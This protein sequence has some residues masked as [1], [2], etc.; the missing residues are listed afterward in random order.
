MKN[1]IR[2]FLMMDDGRRT[3][4]DTRQS[5]A[6]CH[7][8]MGQRTYPG[9]NAA[10]QFNSSRGHVF[11]FSFLSFLSF[12][13]SSCCGVVI[14][15]RVDGRATS[16]FAYSIIIIIIIITPDV[17]VVEFYWRLELLPLLP[18]LCQ[19]RKSSA[20]HTAYKYS[21]GKRGKKRKKCVNYE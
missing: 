2:D 10:T 1:E 16:C 8:M 7:S 17:V 6:S 19:W 20:F 18:L 14:S 3:A 9:H 13:S 4:R 11:A 5:D 21:K 15:I 12:V